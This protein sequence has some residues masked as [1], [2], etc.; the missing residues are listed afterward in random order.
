LGRG[1]G[2]HVKSISEKFHLLITEGKLNIKHAFINAENIE[3]LF[4]EMAVPKEF[5]LLSIDIDGNDYWVWRAIAQYHPRVVAIEYN[6]MFPA[7]LKYV[8]KYDSN[9]VYAITS[10]FGA[11]LKSLEI[12]GAKKGYK[13]VGC[14][15]VGANAFFVR[16]D[17]VEDHFLSP[18]TAEAH[19]ESPKYFL[20]NKTGHP[21]DFGRFECV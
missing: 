1:G 16:D 18:F 6:A 14:N 20:L 5:D 17:L 3:A 19:Y 4:E 7:H 13:L 11:S 21:R 2:D 10:Y 15:F 9:K 12:L 8:V